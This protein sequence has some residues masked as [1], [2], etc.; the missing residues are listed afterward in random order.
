[1]TTA[2]KRHPTRN[3]LMLKSLTMTMKWFPQTKIQMRKLMKIFRRKS[4]H[5]K[6]I[7]RLKSLRSTN[8]TCLK[9]TCNFWKFSKTTP[10]KSTRASSRRALRSR[11]KNSK[12]LWATT[13]SCQR[14]SWTYV[15]R[16]SKRSLFKRNKRRRSLTFK[17]TMRMLFLWKRKNQTRKKKG[18]Q[19]QS[20]VRIFAKKCLQANQSR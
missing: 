13:N 14:N 6:E 10:S 18:S 1:M 8:S 19:K 12:S 16:R 2:L 9:L 7:Y 15:W 20:W 11:R 17:S 5:H 3:S 4:N